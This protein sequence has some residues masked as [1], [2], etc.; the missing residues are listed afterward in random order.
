[1]AISID[2][3]TRVISV[4][5]ADLTL[6]SGSLYEMDTAD[7][8]D[9]LKDLED[10]EEGMPFP[11]THIHNVPVTVAGSTYARTIE[12]INGYSITFEDT[13]SPYTV[14]LVGSNNNIFDV[15]NGILNPTDGVTVVATNSAGYI[16]IETGVSGLTAA[17][18]AAWLA[19]QARMEVMEKIM[20]NKRRLLP[21]SG[22][23]ILYEDDSATPAMTRQVYEDAGGTQTYRGRGHERV[24]R[25]EP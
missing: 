25:F 18:S 16:Q 9:S 19:M 7:F 5:K 20:R 10:S 21:T 24:E 4:P 1:M 6:I 17:E 3:G 12:I 13:G 11:D 22:T 8:R 15:E 2:W 23:E 14:R